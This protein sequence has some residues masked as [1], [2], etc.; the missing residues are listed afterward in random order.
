[1]NF[2]AAL[3]DCPWLVYNNSRDDYRVVA[4]GGPAAS[5]WA[6]KLVAQLAVCCDP[7]IK[8]GFAAIVGIVAPPA[9]AGNGAA[10]WLAF[11]VFDAGTFL[12]R[13]HT[14]AVVA[15]EV[16]PAKQRPWRVSSLLAA[17]PTPQPGASDYIFPQTALPNDAP[18]NLAGPF[19]A[20]D[21]WERSAASER[22]L[23][24][25][26]ALPDTALPN[27]TTLSSPPAGDAPWFAGG[28]LEPLQEFCRGRYFTPVMLILATIAAVGGFLMLPRPGGNRANENPPAED[29]VASSAELTDHQLLAALNRAGIELPGG[30]S[31]QRI[32]QAVVAAARSAHERLADL[33]DDLAA[34]SARVPAAPQAILQ[35]HAQRWG[36][37]CDISSPSATGEAAVKSAVA[38][39]RRYVQAREELQLLE[40]LAPDTPD[41]QRELT[42]FQARLQT[43][44]E[45]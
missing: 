9:A 27:L 37:P 3:A 26:F 42:A 6:E 25:C 34:D 45:R 16:P 5:A 19:A 43:E 2:S 12:S 28:L 31:R 24:I 38:T 30:F 13:P 11:R 1:M 41:F 18:K 17:L 44:L 14:V 39:L 21:A 7:L 22:H 23:P 35:R 20:L 32:E 4:R 40:K 10:R 29:A 33:H 8:P 36:H 15:V